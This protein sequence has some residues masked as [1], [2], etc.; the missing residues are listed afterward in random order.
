RLTIVWEPFAVPWR[1]P[2]EDERWFAPTARLPNQF[3]VPGGVPPCPCEATIVQQA[4]N[5]PAPARQFDNGNLGARFSGR[6]GTTDFAVV[7][8]DGY[9][10][11]PSFSVAARLDS[12]SIPSAAQAVP[13]TAMTALEPA[14]RR[15]RS[16]GADAATP[17]GPLTVRAE[18]AWRFR[19]PYPFA[20]N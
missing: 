5:S 17:I 11:T 18:A 14:Y 1:F 13:V 10:P 15:F 2:L 6:L 12:A 3:F 9:D 4:R 7:S 16:L 20:L 8:F 19:R